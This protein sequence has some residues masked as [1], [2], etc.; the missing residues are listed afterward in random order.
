[1]KLLAVRAHE[2]RDVGLVRY[3]PDRKRGDTAFLIS[4]W[5][6]PEARGRGVGGALVEALVECARSEGFARMEL[7]VGDH[8]A[9]AIALYAKKGFDATGERGRLAPPREHLREHRRLL[10]LTR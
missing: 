5:V 8:N 3:G 7:D 1:M 2:G 9:A 4:M 10:V 6:A